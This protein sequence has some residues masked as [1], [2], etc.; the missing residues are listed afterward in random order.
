MK[1]AIILLVIAMCTF[2][3]ILAFALAKISTISEEM[4]EEIRHEKKKTEETTDGTGT[5]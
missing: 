2:F 3:V 4:E 5:R 1:I